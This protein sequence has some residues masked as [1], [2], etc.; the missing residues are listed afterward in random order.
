M[1][2]PRAFPG[3][4]AAYDPVTFHLVTQVFAHGLL[5]RADS[6]DNTE[7]EKDVYQKIGELLIESS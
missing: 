3:Q 6:S 5:G 1:P 4:I 2:L 7:F